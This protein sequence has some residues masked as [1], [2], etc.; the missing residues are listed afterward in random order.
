M[1]EIWKTWGCHHLKKMNHP[2]RPNRLVRFRTSSPRTKRL[3]ASVAETEAAPTEASVAVTEAPSPPTAAPAPESTKTYDDKCR[4]VLS[5]FKSMFPWLTVDDVTGRMRCSICM[6]SPTCSGRAKKVWVDEGPTRWQKA[7]CTNHV[8]STAHLVSVAFAQKQA[9]PSTSIAGRLESAV[10][11]HSEKEAAD[12]LQAG[13]GHLQVPPCPPHVLSMAVSIY[14]PPLA[15]LVSRTK[16]AYAVATSSVSARQFPGLLATSHRAALALGATTRGNPLER[17]RRRARIG[18][19]NG[20]GRL[21]ADDYGTR[22]VLYKQLKEK[23][24]KKTKK[25]KKKDSK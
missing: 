9:D 6:K 22:W 18:T 17:T 2:M 5:G 24:A 21:R 23:E 14:T 1:K 25:K 15:T 12:I 19:S 3:E 7:T 13:Q 8:K 16:M 20:R 10:K 11:A 4:S